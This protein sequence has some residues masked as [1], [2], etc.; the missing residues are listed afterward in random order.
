MRQFNKNYY[1]KNVFGITGPTGPQGLDLTGPTGITGPTGNI[2]YTGP[3]GSPGL[4]LTGP[5]GETGETGM[6]GPKGS[7][8]LDLTGPTGHTGE[9]GHTGMTGPTGS[10]GLDLTGPTGPTGETGHTGHTGYTGMTGPT[11]YSI[12]GPT[13][14]VSSR[15]ISITP[16]YVN[17]T[18]ILDETFDISIPSNTLYIDA[19]VCGGGGSITTVD[20]IKYGGGSGGC[21]ILKNIYVNTSMIF[22]GSFQSSTSNGNNAL[23]KFTI[24]NTTYSIVTSY[25]GKNGDY[26]SILSS[27]DLYSSANYLYYKDLYLSGTFSTTNVT[28]SYPLNLSILGYESYG[29]GEGYLDNEYILAG[30]GCIIILC[31][32][33]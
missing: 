10:S 5:T 7:S 33:N 25:G 13:G 16:Y 27:I 2:G 9:T 21:C 19:I 3:T 23:F 30:T 4:D 28:G 20:N 6:T 24:N 18:N 31:Y 1:I 11:G 32:S 12:T 22:T 29:R 26:L 14:P 15:L 17:S 8:G